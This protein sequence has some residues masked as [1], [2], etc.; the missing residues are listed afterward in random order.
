[1]ATVYKAGLEQVQRNK[2]IGRRTIKQVELLAVNF[3]PQL[4]VLFHMYL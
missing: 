1:M 4:P 3:H 2:K